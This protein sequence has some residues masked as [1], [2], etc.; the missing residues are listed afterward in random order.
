MTLKHYVDIKNELFYVLRALFSNLSRIFFMTF[1]SSN[2]LFQHIIFVGNRAFTA[3]S[4]CSFYSSWIIYSPLLLQSITKFD[5]PISGL[6]YRGHCVLE[7]QL[8]DILIRCKKNWNSAKGYVKYF[9]WC[10]RTSRTLLLLYYIKYKNPKRNNRTI[11]HALK[12][13][14][15]RKV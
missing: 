14:C 10:S 6:G 9:R 3:F 7:Q 5:Y 11:G 2:A 8:N 12:P 1:H 15:H 13:Q 4:K